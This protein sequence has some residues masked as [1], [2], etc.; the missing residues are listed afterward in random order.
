MSEWG[1][2]NRKSS[3]AADCYA[4]EEDRD[5]G[6]GDVEAGIFEHFHEA[7]FGKGGGFAALPSPEEGKEA[8]VFEAVEDLALVGAALEG[9]GGLRV[10]S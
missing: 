10:E 6:E 8:G 3:F 4:A 2:A 9:S 1:I 7:D 5:A